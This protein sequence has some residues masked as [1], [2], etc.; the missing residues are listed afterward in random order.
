MLRLSLEFQQKNWCQDKF[1]TFFFIDHSDNREVMPIINA[2]SQP[3]TII[4][5]QARL[6]LTPNILEAYKWTFANVKTDYVAIIE[7]DTIVSQDWLK[8]ML[9]FAENNRDETVMALVAGD[10]LDKKLSGDKN[11]VK[12][13]DRYYSCASI[14]SRTMFEHHVLPHCNEEYYKANNAGKDKYLRKYFPGILEAQLLDQMGLFRRAKMKNKLKVICPVFRRFGHIGVYGRF[15]GKSSL[16]QMKTEQRY[17]VLK[18]ACYSQVELEKWASLKTGNFV[19]FE[20]N[21][22]FGKEMIY[23]KSI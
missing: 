17:E 10:L 5:R 21:T 19:D 14:V 12:C 18:K 6:D 23:Q 8:M 16:E 13:I 22:D 2:Y 4:S 3:K 15:H 7:D 9:W 1:M 11:V 20:P